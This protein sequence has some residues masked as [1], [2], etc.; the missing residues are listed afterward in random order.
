MR[1]M[2]GL[3]GMDPLE[4]NHATRHP[5]K[6]DG[7]LMLGLGSPHQRL[8]LPEPN[9]SQCVSLLSRMMLAAVKA[10]NQPQK[11]KQP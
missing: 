7:Q 2:P 11:A 9:R 3:K 6:R 5:L 10:N 8:C 4:T 1:K